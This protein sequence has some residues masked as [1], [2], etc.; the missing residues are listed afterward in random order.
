LQILS[1]NL[2]EDHEDDHGLEED[3]GEESE[4]P[5]L[6][7]LPYVLTFVGYCIVLLVDKVL[8]GHYS[9]NHERL[10]TGGP[11][12]SEHPIAPPVC[13]EHHHSVHQEHIELPQSHPDCKVEDIGHEKED[14]EKSSPERKP[15]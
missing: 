11:P 9:H 14:F 10:A 5:K 7:P 12:C 4:P 13:N 8:A 3:H 6:F 2:E 1:K 15:I